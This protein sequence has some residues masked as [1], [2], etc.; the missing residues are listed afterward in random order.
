MISAVRRSLVGAASALAAAPQPGRN[1]S[2]QLY[3]DT[4][5]VQMSSI[6]GI[7]QKKLYVAWGSA[8]S[9]CVGPGYREREIPIP[10]SLSLP[11]PRPRAR[12][13]P[14]ALARTRFPRADAPAF[15][16]GGRPVATGLVVLGEPRRYLLADGR[17]RRDDRRLVRRRRGVRPGVVRGA[18]D[19]EHLCWKQGPPCPGQASQAARAS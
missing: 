15:P 1:R 11:P 3:K 18:V 10:N 7:V 16:R 6:K 12:A 2:S 19:H 9:F 17:A 13:K 4:N 14:R 5:N 8:H